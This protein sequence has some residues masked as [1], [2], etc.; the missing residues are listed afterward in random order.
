[1]HNALQR[2]YF[3]P[4]KVPV[5]GFNIVPKEKSIFLKKSWSDEFT[6]KNFWT[7]LF[8]SRKKLG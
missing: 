7:G 4:S 8:C 1:M 2:K 6:W 5:L 3:L